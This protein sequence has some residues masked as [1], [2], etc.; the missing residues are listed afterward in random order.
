MADQ[1]NGLSANLTSGG[2]FQM[3]GDTAFSGSVAR[4]LA[5]L[6]GCEDA[7]S[8]F[9]QVPGGWAFT[10]DSS[11]VSDAE[12]AAIIASVKNG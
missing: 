9:E 5:E 2:A 1:E 8:W 6:E 3:T 12:R 4:I 7:R 10:K 11:F